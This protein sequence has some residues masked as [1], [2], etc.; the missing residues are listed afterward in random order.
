MQINQQQKYNLKMITTHEMNKKLK[1]NVL[2]LSTIKFDVSKYSVGIF[3]LKVVYKE[4]DK[5][6]FHL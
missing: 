3:L 4:D 1:I 5:N 2:I 6:I